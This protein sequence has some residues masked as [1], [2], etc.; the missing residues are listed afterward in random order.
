M[1][2]NSSYFLS[3]VEQANENF[4]GSD[5]VW[6]A[7]SDGADASFDAQED[8]NAGGVHEVHARSAQESQPYIIIMTNTGTTTT[9]NVEILNANVNQFLAIASGSLYSAAGSYTISFGIPNVTYQMFLSSVA[10]GVVFQVGISRLIAINGTQ[11]LATGQ[12]QETVLIT[13]RDIN[14]NS[15]ARP[16]IPILDNY[17]FQQAQVDIRYDYLVNGL[18]SFILGNLYGSTTVKVLLY[19]ARKVNQFSHLKGK[20]ITAYRNPQLD[21]ALRA[22]M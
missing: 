6:S 14:G 11:S 8:L 21:P 13:S 18:T 20:A 17:Q 7:D 2:N 16:F 4:L 22:K 1:K 9:P 3:Q 15:V 10:S 12:V 19:P 5:G